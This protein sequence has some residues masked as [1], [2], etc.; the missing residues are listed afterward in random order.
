MELP[1][2]ESAI[3][4]KAAPQVPF[5]EKGSFPPPAP[6]PILQKLHKKRHL[7]ISNFVIIFIK[8]FLT[9]NGENSIIIS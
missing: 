4:A 9:D 6:T 1:I 5:W 2:G 7:Q 3:R 8:F